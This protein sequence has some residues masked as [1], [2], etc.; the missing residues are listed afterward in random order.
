MCPERDST[1]VTGQRENNDSDDGETDDDLQEDNDKENDT[2]DEGNER[3]LEKY[4]CPTAFF[5]E[6]IKPSSYI[7]LHSY[8]HFELFYICKVLETCIA[9]EDDVDEYGH[10]V[11]KGET[12]LKCHYLSH[13]KEKKKVHYYKELYTPVHVNPKQILSPF[14]NITN[15]LT[16]SL[17]Y[18]QFICDEMK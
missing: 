13:I 10:T 9:E 17:A 1:I 18:Y 2:E 12:Y 11:R 7:A 15:E 3:G 16:L 6:I 4:E 5:H 14:V 8:S